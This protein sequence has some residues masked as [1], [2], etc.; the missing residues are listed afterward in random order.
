MKKSIV[1]VTDRAV[2]RYLELV[3]GMDIEMVRSEIGRAV[4]LSLDHPQACGVVSG[5][6]TFKLKNGVVTTV[7][8]HHNPKMRAGRRGVKRERDE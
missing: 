4:D 1:K 5:G 6:F 7:A 3:R 2:V 8:A